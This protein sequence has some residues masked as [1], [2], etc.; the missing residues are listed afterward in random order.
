VPVKF[1]E[2]EGGVRFAVKVVPGASRDRIVGALGDALKVAVSKPPQ[3]GAA[4]AAVVALLAAAL[5][6][7]D[8]SVRIVRGHGSP[9]KEL[10]VEGLGARQAAER[11]GAARPRS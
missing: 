2:L 11:L 7:P 8:S 6:V 1:V 10:T 3:G 4:N 5:G 9:R